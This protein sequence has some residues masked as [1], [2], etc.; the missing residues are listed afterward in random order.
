[1]ALSLAVRLRHRDHEAAGAAAD[2]QDAFDAGEVVV[3]RGGDRSR[4]RVRLHRGCDLLGLA[5]LD[6]ARGPAV[7][8]AAGSRRLR[9][10][11]GTRGLRR[12]L[13]LELRERG[14]AMPVADA[15]PHHVAPIERA[16]CHEIDLR[17]VR[18]LIA[19]LPR[20]QELERGEQAQHDA[21]RARV[22]IEPLRELVD[23]RG[24]LRE[25][26]KNPRIVGGDDRALVEAREPEV[27]DLLVVA[28]R[29][30]ILVH[31]LS[32]GGH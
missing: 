5:D 7:G 9:R 2:V 4:Q 26:A 22:E 31:L 1:M 20:H 27:P 24:A 15:H 23:R 16:R 29:R 28:R 18:E 3:A 30:S 12:A 32:P 6:F 21:G 25:R 19:S 14:V 8:R 10:A 11:F 13:L 17:C